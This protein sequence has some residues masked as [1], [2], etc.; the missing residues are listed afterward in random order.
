MLFNSL[1]FFIFLGIFFVGWPFLR[2][3]NNLRWIYLVVFSFFFYGWWD[4]R[5]LALLVATAGVD[6]LAG[7]GMVRWP[8]SKKLLLTVSLSANVGSLFLF[9]YLDF[10]LA[11]GNW[12][13]NSF[14]SS[15]QI[16]LAHLVLP[17]GIS[18]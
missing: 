7:M 13:L 5:Y 4:F 15:F 8:A 18:F 2:R 14:G 12:L 11:N 16:P 6:Y 9:K 1:E 3:N 17:I 10:L